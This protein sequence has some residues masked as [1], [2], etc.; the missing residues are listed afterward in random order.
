MFVSKAFHVDFELLEKNLRLMIERTIP[1]YPEKPI[2]VYGDLCLGLNGELKK[3]AEE[4]GLTKIDALNCVDCLLGGKGKIEEADPNHEY[5]FMD[6]G[7]IEFFRDGKEKMKQ[8]GIDEEAFRELFS[9]IKG[10]IL[11]DSLG[12]A[13]KC[14]AETKKLNTG[15]AVLETNE[16]G[17]NN[18]RK[19]LSE[20]TNKT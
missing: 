15:L 1:R 14:K 6:P 19:L 4:Y 5:L 16:V 18:L 11:L 9:G 20:A 3:L 17:L 7:M 2:L 8:E 12:E 10:I 13:E